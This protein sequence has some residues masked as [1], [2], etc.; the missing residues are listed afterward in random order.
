MYRI[1]TYLRRVSDSTPLA[2]A[3]FTRLADFRHG[4]RRFLHFSELAAADEGLTPLQ[5]QALLAIRGHAQGQMNVGQLAERLILKH[6]TVVELVQRLEKAGLLRKQRATDDH[7]VVLLEL[8]AIGTARLDRLSRGHR[9]ELAR[10]GPEI[11][12]LLSDFQPS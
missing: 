10:F 3:D 6:H 11:T 8:T 7:R 9:R 1:T 5:H 2:D 4:L 12:A